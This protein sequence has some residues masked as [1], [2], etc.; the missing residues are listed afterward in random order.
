MLVKEFNALR[1]FSWQERNHKGERLCDV[2]DIQLIKL[3][4]MLCTDA[5]VTSVKEVFRDRRP[6]CIV[7]YITNGKHTKTSAHPWGGAIDYEIRGL[8]LYEQV[9]MASLFPYTGIGF[10]PYTTPCFVHAD[11]KTPTEETLRVVMR[12]RMWYRDAD[13]VYQDY[14]N[15]QDVIHKL[16]GHYVPDTMNGS[17]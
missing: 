2:E 9:I 7:H 15:F 10:Y 6:A 4:L 16:R 5:M 11:I 13:K 17:D 12:R 1:N 14:Q 8:S 3:E